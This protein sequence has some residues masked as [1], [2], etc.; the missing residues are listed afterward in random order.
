MSRTALYQKYRS[1]TFDQVV[2]QE[3]IVQAIRNAVSENKVG[4]AYLFCGPRGTGKT[5]MARLLAKAVNCKNIEDAPCG[6]CDSCI[7]AMEGKHPDIIEINAAN[8]THVEDI[9]ELI[10]RAQLAPML[11]KYKVYIVDEVHQLSTSA[12]SALL[13]TLEEPPAHVIFIL[14]TTDPQKLLPTII[15]RCQRFDFSKVE[16]DK[17]QKHLLF[18]AENEGF[19]L[20]SEAAY[21]IAE[22]ADGGMRDALSILEQASAYERGVIKEETI[23]EIFGL[24]SDENKV[25]F[26]KAIMDTKL[27]EVIEMIRKSQQDGIDLKFLTVDLSAV[28]K[29]T[30]IYKYTNNPSL[31]R[32]ISKEQAE[33]LGNKVTAAVALEMIRILNEATMDYRNTSSIADYFEFICMKLMALFAQ[34]EMF[35]VKQNTQPQVEEVVKVQPKPVQMPKPVEKP[36]ENA[37]KPQSNGE[38]KKIV[39]NFVETVENQTVDKPVVRSDIKPQEI[40][41]K[42]AIGILNQCDKEHK[43][44]DKESMNRLLNGL[45]MNRYIGLLRQCEIKAS[46][47]DCMLLVTNNQ[48]TASL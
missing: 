40:T 25:T 4:H 34:A 26:L 47:E 13:K 8:E 18:I 29:D 24:A 39:E 42:M 7:D 41:Q 3:Y 28:L 21:K 19:E 31:L 30:V 16:I 14:A 32:T 1:Q 37:L 5:T 12:S 45:A 48:A 27:E 23:N 17:I 11:G 6:H 33:D 44:L 20:E 46:G 43:A 9:R 36:V 38:N 35:H 10:E 15:S 22:L 2:G